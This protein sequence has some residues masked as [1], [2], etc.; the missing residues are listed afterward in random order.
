MAPREQFDRELKDL[1]DSVIRMGLLVDDHL[2]MAL[3]AFDTLDTELAKQVIVF[4]QKVNTSRF[5]IEEACFKLIVTQQPAARDL[6][7]IIAAM[8]IIVDLERIGD[9]AKDIAHTI[10][11]I[12][13]KPNLLRPPELSRMGG[14]VRSMV[15]QCMQ[16]YGDNS[17]EL[18]RLVADQAKELD[19]LSA[20]VLDQT[21][22]HI[23]KAKKE[24]KVTASFGVLRAAQHLDRVGDLAINVAERVIYIGTGSVQ[25]MKVH[26]KDDPD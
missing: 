26:L 3:K 16:A 6:R 2:K 11:P 17:V 13:E 8:N 12:L 23:V 7:A 14:L 24:R 4:D 21:I 18:A 22:E 1:R 10:G 19:T 20:E 5:S 25:E 9:K 15:Q